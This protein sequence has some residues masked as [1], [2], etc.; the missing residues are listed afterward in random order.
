MAGI[1][2]NLHSSSLHLLIR[3]MITRHRLKPMLYQASTGTIFKILGAVLLL[4]SLCLPMA[5]CT[6]YADSQ[7]FPIV[8]DRPESKPGGVREVD[9]GPWYAMEDLKPAEPMFWMV[10]ASFAWP[11][12][13]V[14]LLSWRGKGRI[15]ILLRVI[16]PILLAYSASMVEFI[17]TFLVTQR[18]IGAYVAFVGLGTYGIGI[19]LTDLAL[20]RLWKMRNH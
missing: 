16:E 14:A 12:L 6:Y 19:V 18:E 17:S 8:V 11:L 9:V 7:G 4:V 20:F 5:S 13:W 1:Y 2:S 15:A 10:L 3:L